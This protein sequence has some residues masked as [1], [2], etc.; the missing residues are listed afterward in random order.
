MKRFQK[1]TQRLDDVV[2]DQRRLLRP[3]IAGDG[4]STVTRIDGGIRNAI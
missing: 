4:P 3:L 2:H 1:L